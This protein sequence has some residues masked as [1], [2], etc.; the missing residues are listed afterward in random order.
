MKKQDDAAAVT[1]PHNGTQ[2][3]KEA[4]ERDEAGIEAGTEAGTEAGAQGECGKDASEKGATKRHVVFCG[5]TKWDLLGRKTIPKAVIT[6]GGSDAGE[7]HLAPKRVAFAGMGD[8]EFVKIYAGP[9][10]AHMILIDAKGTAYGVGRNDCG[11]LGCTDLKTRRAPVRFEEMGCVEMGSCGRS[12]S[13]LLLRDGSVRTVGANQFGQLGNGHV[14]D[15][16]NCSGSWETFRLPE[17]ETGVW[18]AAGAEFSV[19]VCGSGAVYTAGYGQYG[20]LGNGRSGE[21]II[22]AGRVAY[23]TVSIPVRAIFPG[24]VKIRQVAC[25]TNHSVALD[26][27]GKVWSW[28]FGGYG[29]LGHRLQKDEWV[30]KRI[31]VFEADTYR[32]DL[33]RCGASASYAVQRS[34]KSAYFWGVTKKSGESNMYPKPMFDIQGWEIRDLGCGPS[35]TVVA[36]ENSVISWG[37]SPTFGEL[38]Y[39]QGGKKSSTQPKKMDALE[40]AL[41]VQVAEGMAFTAMLVEGGDAVDALELLTLTEEEKATG[42]GKAKRKNAGKGKGAKAKR[43]KR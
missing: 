2:T 4:T 43:K 14:T 7:E 22:M 15:L 17:G 26:A 34:R 19:V 13:V 31:E 8:V 16:K 11:Q 32:L 33:V 24:D 3:D 23:D 21:H 35:S 28:G 38:G 37:P 6:R 18:V 39:G 36:A 40:G 1:A 25:G 12:H 30:P 27:D 10:A 29:R 9:V 41:C 20:Q 5:S 42:D